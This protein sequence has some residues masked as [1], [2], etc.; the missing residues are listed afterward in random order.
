MHSLGDMDMQR[1]DEARTGINDGEVQILNNSDPLISDATETDT[2]VKATSGVC[3]SPVIVDNVSEQNDLPNSD[4]R[5]ATCT[6]STN[7]DCKNT[8]KTSKQSKKV[9]KNRQ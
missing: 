9:W 2:S 6:E 8:A 5:E 4:S 3:I 1:G 7:L